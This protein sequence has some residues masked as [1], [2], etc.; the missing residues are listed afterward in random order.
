M[1]FNAIKLNP[2]QEIKIIKA[3]DEALGQETLFFDGKKKLAWKTISRGQ[4][5]FLRPIICLIPDD[6][7]KE[8][9]LLTERFKIFL[10]TDKS[11]LPICFW[12]KIKTPRR[13]AMAPIPI[14]FE[15]GK[16]NFFDLQN[17][18]LEA[19]KI[20]PPEERDLGQ[21]FFCPSS[22]K[23]CRAEILKNEWKIFDE[24]WKKAKVW[25]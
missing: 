7:Q 18:F 13:E 11:R 22:F 16:K 23:L 4:I 3:R 20:M 15:W 14:A 25:Q 6:L 2:S 1:T 9:F 21:S 24:V 8:E 12:A 5:V 17:P 19:K 10:S